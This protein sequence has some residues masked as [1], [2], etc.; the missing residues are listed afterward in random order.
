MTVAIGW[1]VTETSDLSEERPE[2]FNHR[3]AA[4]MAGF[5]S[6]WRTAKPS[7]WSKNA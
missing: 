5:G 3:L 4:A 2:R 1:V 6:I 7:F